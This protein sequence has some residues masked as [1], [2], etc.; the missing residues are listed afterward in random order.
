MLWFVITLY[1][2]NIHHKCIATSA[3]TTTKFMMNLFVTK[4]LPHHLPCRLTFCHKDFATSSA[5][6]LVISH[7]KGTT[8]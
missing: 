7:I 4:F 3:A 1:D 6:T 2:E 8:V 5:V